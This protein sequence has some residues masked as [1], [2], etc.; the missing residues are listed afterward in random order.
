ML[1]DALTKTNV[2]NLCAFI[3]VVCGLGYAIHK[4][5]T[6]LVKAA[7]LMALGYLFGRITA[8]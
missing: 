3:V 1:K 4:G 5:E 7:L 6:E 2:A 8:K